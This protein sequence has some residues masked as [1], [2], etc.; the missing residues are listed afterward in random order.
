MG[1]DTPVLSYE[2]TWHAVRVGT[3][4]KLWIDDRWSFSG[5]FA[6]VPYAVVQ[7]KD[8]HLLRQ[9]S[10]D[11]GPA[12]NVITKSHYAYGVE[13]ELFVNY[14]RHAQH[15]NRRRRALLGA[16]VPHGRRALRT[17]LRQ[18]PINSTNFDQERYGVLVHAKGRF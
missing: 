9:D 17:G 1:F 14:A 3:E 5:E 8:S 4:G 12:P 10:A 13:A 18:R 15:R 11:L 7:N 6:V 16:G 2:P